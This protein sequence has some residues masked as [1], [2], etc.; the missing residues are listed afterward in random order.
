MNEWMNEWLQFHFIHGLVTTMLSYDVGLVT[1]RK[2]ARYFDATL[3]RQRET[4]PKEY[5]R[6]IPKNNQSVCQSILC[7]TASACSPNSPL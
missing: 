2:Y 3:L 6:H 5:L 7:H 1:I 4:D